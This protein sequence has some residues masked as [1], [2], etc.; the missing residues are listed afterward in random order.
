MILFSAKARR[1]LHDAVSLL[2]DAQQRAQWR[3]WSANHPQ[4]RMP[5]GPPDDG[6]GPLPHDIAAIALA[7]LE[8]KTLRLRVE[9]SD[10]AEDEVFAFDNDL[11]LIRSIEA[12]LVE[13]R[14][15][16]HA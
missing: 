3:R 8:A 13:A 11:S 16:V 4:A 12:M 6:A 5:G 9:R 10:A 1:V 2:P 14:N 15:A 7:A